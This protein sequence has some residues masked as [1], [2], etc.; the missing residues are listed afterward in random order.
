LRKAEI[1]VERVAVVASFDDL[2]AQ[3]PT[4]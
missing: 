4:A 1:E 2:E 3:K